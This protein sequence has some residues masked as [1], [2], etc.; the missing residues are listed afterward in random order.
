M[1]PKRN[2]DTVQMISDFMHFYPWRSAV[3]LVC[4][5]FA[6]LSECIGIASLLP[7]L[8]IAVGVNNSNNTQLEELIGTV[9]STIS[10][11]PSLGML[12]ILIVAGILLKSGFMLFAMRQVG[13]TVA[14][15]VTDFRLKLFRSLLKARWD[16]FINQSV[17]VFTNAISTEAMRLS[18]GYQLTCMILAEVIQ[19]FFYIS[20]AVLISWQITAISLIVAA[21]ITLSLKPL[22]GVSR[23]A[24]LQQTEAF[25]FLLA[26]MT[27]M[28]NGIKPIKAMGRENHLSPLLEKESIQLKKAL[29][30][31]V[32]SSEMLKTFQEPL[33]IIFLAIGIYIILK[34]WSVPMTSLLIMAFLFHRTVNRIGR[35]Q[36]Q[37]QALTVSESAYWSFRQKIIEIESADEKDEGV[38]LPEFKNNLELKN[39]NFSYGDKTIFENVSFVIPFAR[40]TLITGISGVGKT[41]LVDMITRLVEPDDGEIFVDA[42]PLPNIDLKKWRHNIGYVPQEMFLFHE[43]IFSNITLGDE[44]LTRE[45]VE[46]VLY[47]A[48]AMDFVSALP[49]GMDSIVG[50]RGAKISGGQRQRISIARALIRKPK[51]LILDEVTTAL[52]PKTEA[53]ICKTLIQL[54]DD[55]AIIAISHQTA[56]TDVADLIYLVKDGKI[57][58]LQYEGRVSKI[59]G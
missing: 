31:Q 39:I 50:E 29:E 25:Q 54:K 52:D 3:M 22:I 13:Y 15:V 51:L 5:L 1:I 28:L 36:K 49:Q 48:G 30:K 2:S 18:K 26:R 7:L 46:E 11:E 43:S 24:G 34:F 21:I 32:L 45:D 42:V 14:Y 40:L 58:E 23:R 12:L 8:N 27:D 59:Y 16:Y 4:L 6:G 56:M 33:L 44:Q 19:V 55:M 17:G 57:E 53:D 37:Y 9:F 35:V 47:K 20:L 41:T 38:I 10:L